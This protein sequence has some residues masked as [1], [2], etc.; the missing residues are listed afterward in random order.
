MRSPPLAPR[1]NSFSRRHSS[2]STSTTTTTTQGRGRT[3]VLSPPP[4]LRASPFSPQISVPLGASG[5]SSSIKLNRRRRRAP[6]PASLE[7]RRRARAASDPEEGE[8]ASQDSDYLTVGDPRYEMGN[9]R[10]EGTDQDQP[11]A[12]TT[13]DDLSDSIFSPTVSST[14]PVSTTASTPMIDAPLSSSTTS[15]T[16]SDP[17][18]PSSAPTLDFSSAGETDEP[19]S[20]RRKFSEGRDERGGGR[21]WLA[22]TSSWW[23]RTVEIKVWH[24]LGLAGVLVGVGVGAGYV[25]WSCWDFIGSFLS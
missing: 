16:P 2:S 23:R 4:A 21:T 12:N 20:K 5:D 1:R 13:S 11:S 3:P 8:A 18:L 15:L 9:A 22:W 10:G 6:G 14:Q 17:Y 24:L 25:V 7:E 19:S